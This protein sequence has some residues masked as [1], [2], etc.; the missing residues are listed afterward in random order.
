MLIRTRFDDSSRQQATASTRPRSP[1]RFVGL[2]LQTNL[3]PNIRLVLLG[4]CN[5]L[6]VGEIT[7]VK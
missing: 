4:I 7:E 1:S 3:I 5:N 2:D 6:Q